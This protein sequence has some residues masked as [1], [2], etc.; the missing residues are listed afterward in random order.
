M[1]SESF[2]IWRSRCQRV[3]LDFYALKDTTLTTLNGSATSVLVIFWIYRLFVVQ[4]GTY[5]QFLDTKTVCSGSFIP[6]R[7]AMIEVM[8][9]YAAVLVLHHQRYWYG[10]GATVL[11]Q[12]RYAFG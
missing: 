4:Y 7:I 2:G 1:A 8:S 3:G 6:F 9:G 5:A 11:R 10:S 12:Q